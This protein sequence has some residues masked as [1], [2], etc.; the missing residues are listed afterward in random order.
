MNQYWKANQ[1]HNFLICILPLN[2]CLFQHNIC[3]QEL[4]TDTLYNI[5]CKFRLIYTLLNIVVFLEAIIG[6]EIIKKKLFFSTV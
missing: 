1:H 6:S 4:Y 5:H 3:H 2:G